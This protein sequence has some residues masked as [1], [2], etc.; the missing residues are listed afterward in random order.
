MNYANILF[1]RML[2]DMK[3]RFAKILNKPIKAFI[4]VLEVSNHFHAHYH[5]CIIIDRLIVKKMPE[6]MKFEGLWGQRTEFSFVRKGIK[7]YMSKYFAKEQYRLCYIDHKGQL[8]SFRSFGIN[9][10]K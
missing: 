6:S 3:Y 5:I 7:R 4:W 8:K 10:L 9:K 2:D 1:S